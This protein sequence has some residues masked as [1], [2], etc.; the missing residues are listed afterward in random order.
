MKDKIKLSI[1]WIFSFLVITFMMTFSSHAQ[2]NSLPFI[3]ANSNID[4]LDDFLN[5][6]GISNSN[7]Q[8]FKNAYN[9][10]EY[11]GTKRDPSPLEDP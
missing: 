8:V 2:G 6:V 10:G 11:F 7:Y 4:G 5:Q 9:N 1:F 3:A